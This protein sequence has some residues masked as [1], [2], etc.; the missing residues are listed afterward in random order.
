MNKGVPNSRLDKKQT[1]NLWKCHMLC[2]SVLTYGRNRWEF[3][4]VIRNSMGNEIW[5]IYYDKYFEIWTFYTLNQYNLYTSFVFVVVSGVLCRFKLA[6]PSLLFLLYNGRS[7][8]ARPWPRL[9]TGITVSLGRLRCEY[10]K[11]TSGS[12]SSEGISG[13]DESDS[14]LFNDQSENRHRNFCRM[15][16]LSTAL[17]KNNQDLTRS[18]PNSK[19]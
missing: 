19:E 1:I 10:F 5:S 18:K 16:Q 12:S 9:I 4:R 7:R 8:G 15:R 11:N 17:H 3:E 6:L 2:D 13:E 14:W